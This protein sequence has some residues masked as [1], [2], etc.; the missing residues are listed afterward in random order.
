AT[1]ISRQ[2]AVRSAKSY[3]SV[4]AFSRQGLIDQLHSPYGERYSKADAVYGVDHAG[5][6]WFKQAVRSARS[7]LR[8]SPFSRQVLLQ[9][10]ESPYGEKFTH[11]QA[12]YA[13]RAVG[14]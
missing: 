4:G 10:L 7:Y 9:Q 1:S 11:A 13:A 5:A 2:N 3:L 8:T 6:N 14:L 12:V